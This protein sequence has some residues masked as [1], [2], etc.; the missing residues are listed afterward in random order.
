MLWFGFVS[1]TAARP[2]LRDAIFGLGGD[3]T[4]DGGA[5]F[6]TVVI[7]SPASELSSTSFTADG[8]G[9]VFAIRTRIGALVARTIGKYLVLVHKNVA[10]AIDIC[11]LT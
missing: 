1:V 5:G 3:D 7:A 4:I 6:D 10:I 2:P 9:L 8:S 11:R